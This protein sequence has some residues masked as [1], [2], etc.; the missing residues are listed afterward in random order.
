MHNGRLMPQIVFVRGES[1]GILI[2]VLVEGEAYYLMTVQLRFPIGEPEFIE[3]P[4]GM[5]DSSDNFAGVAA[6]EIRE[7]TGIA[8]NKEDLVPL[9]YIYPSPGGCDEKIG[10]FFYE[11]Q[12]S[13]KEFEG[14]KVV[15]YGAT[16]GYENIKLIFVPERKFSSALIDFGDV[17]AEVAYRRYLALKRTR[18]GKVVAPKR[19][20]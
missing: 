19:I 14:M 8:I 20:A 13:R 5:L 18:S 1:V 12:V 10:L 11:V 17:K 15:V 2:R 7:E 6:K 9:G 3:C 4:A 16:D